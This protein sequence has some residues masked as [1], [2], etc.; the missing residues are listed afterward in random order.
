MRSKTIFIRIYYRKSHSIFAFWSRRSMGRLDEWRSKNHKLNANSVVMIDTKWQPLTAVLPAKIPTANHSDGWYRW[1]KFCTQNI[2]HDLMMQFI[3]YSGNPLI[4]SHTLYAA[5]L[6]EATTHR[7]FI[8]CVSSWM[9]L[10]IL[11][12]RCVINSLTANGQTQPRWI[13]AFIQQ[14]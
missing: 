8:H 5:S 12:N 14:K 11:R 6:Q 9:V 7:R 10:W 2:N 4:L 13:V 3:G 1:A